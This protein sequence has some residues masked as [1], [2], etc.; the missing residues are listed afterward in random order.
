LNQKNITILSLNFVLY[1]ITKK[2]I[3]KL[4]MNVERLSPNLHTI[5]L[6]PGCVEGWTDASAFFS[7]NFPQLRSISLGGFTLDD[8]TQAM[9]FW[10]R[11]PKLEY[12]RVITHDDSLW[13]S[14][15]SVSADLLPNVRH[16]KVLCHS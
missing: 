2:A 12:V 6:E 13:F 3:D 16:L 10:K 15:N 8:P 11:H 5:D 1:T 14:K 9:A 4:L 7:L